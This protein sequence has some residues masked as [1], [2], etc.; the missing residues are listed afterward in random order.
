[1]AFVSGSANSV[2]DLLTALQDACVSNGYTLSGS[3]LRKGALYLRATVS[4]GLL[5]IL[6]GTGID[7]SNQLTGAAPAAV[8]LGATVGVPPVVSW[9]VSYSIH[10]LSNPDEV[11]LVVNSDVDQYHWLAF[12]LN[13]AAGITGSGVWY[14]GTESE[15]AP[16]LATKSI[17][18]QPVMPASGEGPQSCAALFWTAGNNNYRTVNAFI[19]HNLDS[20]GWSGGGTTFS[21]VAGDGSAVAGGPANASRGVE[22]TVQR[23]PNAWNSDAVLLPIRPLVPRAS[24]KCSQIGELTHARYIRVTNYDPGEVIPLGSDRW[25]VYPWLRKNTATPNAGSNVTH[26]GTLGWAIRYDG[27]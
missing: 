17:Y 5:K 13:A 27:P 16:A 22:V 9:P 20:V 11:Y 21:T 12:G 1:M 25:R 26:S 14:G 18:I 6:G 19:H 2:G 24:L 8:Q 7:G 15:L 10:V 4:G 23:Q 3:V